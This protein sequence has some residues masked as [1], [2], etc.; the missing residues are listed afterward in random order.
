LFSIGFLSLA[1]QPGAVQPAAEKAW[2][3]D[4]QLGVAFDR[5][6]A[7]SLTPTA[8]LIAMSYEDTR[9]AAPP[10]TPSHDGASLRYGVMALT[11]GGVRDIA[12]ASTLAGASIDQVKTDDATNIRAAAL[13]LSELATKQLGGL[14]RDIEGWRPIYKM[15]SGADDADVQTNYADRLEQLMVDG[16]SAS[17]AAGR[18]L[19]LH[20]VT[21]EAFQGVTHGPINGV[22]THVEGVDYNG[23]LWVAANSANYT[24][25]GED[26][27][28][29][30]IHDMEGSYS[31]SISW[32]QNSAAQ[33][34]AHYMVRSSDGQITQMV[35]EADIAW[36]AG[37]WYYNQHAI[38]IEHEGYLSDPGRWYTEAMYSS[39]AR[40]TA[41]LVSRYSIPVNN[42]HIFGHYQVPASGSGAPC[43]G[44]WAQCDTSAWGGANNHRDPGAGWN[45]SHYFDLVN[46]GGTPRPNYAASYHAQS[47]TMD[48]NSGDVATV[49]LEYTN[50]GAR[51][52]DTTNT[53]VGTT[54]PRD[55]MSPFYDSANWI[56]ASRPTAADH[57]NYATGSVG[58]FSFTMKAPVVTQ[59]T[60]FTE[61]WGLV[62]EGVTWFGP[63]DGAVWFQI[64][65]HPTSTPGGSG[66]SAGAPGGG[67]G[68]SGGSGGGG[69]PGPTPT[70]NPAGNGDMAGGCAAA[71]GMP[72]LS[73]LFLL[74]LLALRRRK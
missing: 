48:M 9:F 45:W 49:Y 31:G 68:G 28:F 60:T 67:S 30:V 24:S 40:L 17:D 6:S 1:C 8:L 55:R 39:S 64:T 18:K 15:W 51:T 56:S 10:T 54:M 50:D 14:P 26:T 3:G 47:Y 12:R 22:G 71:P 61:H 41:H 16:V 5:A 2:G 11:D 29:V 66:G 57:S 58:R 69:E 32:F 72:G 44:T 53:R 63:A 7:E 37:N 20:P 23:A 19:I 52:W 35:R 43:S 21:E 42:A 25:G 62:Q 74:A 33:A 36:H 46:G 34:S 4:S 13:L 65:V 38:G 27:R 70:P 73:P 59:T